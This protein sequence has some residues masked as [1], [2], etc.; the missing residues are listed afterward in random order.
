M[1]ID[2]WFNFW[3]LNFK[4]NHAHDVNY[5]IGLKNI[6][7][8]THNLIMFNILKS[9]PFQVSLVFPLVF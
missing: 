6:F 9:G 2:L 4:C 8:P 5:P 3:F 7:K 1:I